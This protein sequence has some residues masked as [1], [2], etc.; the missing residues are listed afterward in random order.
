[1]VVKA[2]VKVIEVGDSGR[3]FRQGIQAGD[4]GR[5]FRQDC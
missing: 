1:M 5:G 4:S 2:T 3:G